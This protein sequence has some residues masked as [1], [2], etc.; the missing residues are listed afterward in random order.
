MR[1]IDPNSQG[2]YFVPAKPGADIR[3][4]RGNVIIIVLLGM[5]VFGLFLTIVV[6]KPGADSTFA[7]RTP[8]KVSTHHRP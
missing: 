1:P 8:A 6:P 7:S 2:W 3:F 4:R 5:L